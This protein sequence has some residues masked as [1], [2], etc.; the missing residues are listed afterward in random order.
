MNHLKL[1]LTDEGHY[2]IDKPYYKKVKDETKRKKRNDEAR[3]YQR[4]HYLSSNR[5][6]NGA[7]H[8]KG[9]VKRPYTNYCELCGEQ[10]TK[11][12]AYHHWDDLKPEL[13]VWCCWTCH[14]IAEAL[15]CSNFELIKNCYLNLKQHI[16]N[17]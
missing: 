16:K 3:A 9:F 13:G 4:M 1:I 5:L 14:R 8:S 11:R 12:M 15:E 7:I 10:I 17:C 2:E 6:P